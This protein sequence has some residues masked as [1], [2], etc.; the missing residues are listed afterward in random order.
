MKRVITICRSVYVTAVAALVTC[1]SFSL[2][3]QDIEIKNPSL[4]GPP[5]AAAAPP[6]W[7]IINNSPDIQPGCCTVSKPPS[8]GNTY[9][10]MISDASM[11][12]GISQK[13]SAAIK[14]GR[15]YTFSVDLAYPPVY[16]GQK[17]CYGGF[18][19][20]GG[21]TP[22]AKEEVLWKSPAFRHTDWKRYRIEFAPTK[23]YAYILLCNY[24]IPCS[25]AKL[26]GVLVDNLSPYIQEIPRITL[27]T[28]ATCKGANMGAARV[29]VLSGPLP[30]TFKWMPGGQTTHSIDHLSAGSYEVTVTGANGAY[31]TATARIDAVELQNKITITPSKCYGDNTNEISLVTTGGKPPYRYYLNGSD[32]PQYT[33]E[34]RDLHPGKYLLLAKDEMGCSSPEENVTVTEPAPLQ[35]AAA[36]VKDISCSETHDG[37][38]AVVL[39]GGTQPYYY[40]LETGEWQ[41]DS[42]WKKLDE[43]RYYFMAKD[44]NE[45]QLRGSAEIIRNYR[46]CAVYVPTAFSPNGDGRND[47]FRCR[48]NDDITE[49]RLQVFNRWGTLVFQSNDPGQAWDGLRQPAGGYVWVL[50]YTDSKL[51]AR[52]QQGSLV[53]VR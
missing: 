27:T 32:H 18:V 35:L 50:T 16:F 43:G 38:I 51:Q 42:V 17:T 34:F 1:L 40:R 30:Y 3:A 49:Y 15:A 33:P 31:A 10:G 37:Q 29:D 11:E 47:L 48:I 52:K 46:Q 22:G 4:E 19:V 25:D 36:Q 21:N 6:E 5:R 12:E 14:G 8:D 7:T 23:D 53:L 26:G 2:H 28:T 13:L 45:C 39:S 9:S 44:K 24:Y 20:Y 41:S